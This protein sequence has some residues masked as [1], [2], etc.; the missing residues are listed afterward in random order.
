MTIILEIY[1]VLT[2]TKETNFI[3]SLDGGIMVILQI[4]NLIT[5]KNLIIMTMALCFSMCNKE[6][7]ED[8]V[9]SIERTLYTGNELRI[10]GYYYNKYTVSGKNYITIYFF[11]RNG[12]LLYGYSMPINDLTE[13]E[14]EYKNGDF[15]IHAKDL[16][17]IGVHI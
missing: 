2:N 6:K 8:A 12:I 11:Y 13:Q 5:M 7:K 1:V 10:D 14:K 3:S 17:E 15:Y 4:I 9:L 16:K